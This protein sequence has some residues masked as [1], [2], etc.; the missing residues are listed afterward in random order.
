MLNVLTSAYTAIRVQKLW[1]DPQK[2]DCE[3]GIVSPVR[4]HIH[5]SWC[6]LCEM[7]HPQFARKWTNG[8]RAGHVR[9]ARVVLSSPPPLSAR[10]ELSYNY[11]I[12]RMSIHNSQFQLV[13]VQEV[14]GFGTDTKE[15]AVTMAPI[16]TGDQDQEILTML[17]HIAE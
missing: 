5:P 4:I 17:D 3:K 2:D 8:F 10:R 16:C 1:C 13:S 15:W 11:I 12:G 6:T 9:G 14:W 7:K